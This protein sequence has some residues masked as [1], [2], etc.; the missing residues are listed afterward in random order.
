MLQPPGLRLGEPSG[1][2]FCREHNMNP[3]DVAMTGKSA[4]LANLD[5]TVK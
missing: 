5:I 1:A 2:A 3:G 4:M